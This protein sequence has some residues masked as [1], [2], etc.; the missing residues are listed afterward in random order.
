M[1]KKKF[2]LVYMAVVTMLLPEDISNKFNEG[3][4]CLK[5]YLPYAR[6]LSAGNPDSQAHLSD[7]SGLRQPSPNRTKSCLITPNHAWTTR[8]LHAE[9][10]QYG[11]C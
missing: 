3:A 9:F 8:H 2:E 10:R 4:N 11:S 5:N 6:A 7:F 1:T